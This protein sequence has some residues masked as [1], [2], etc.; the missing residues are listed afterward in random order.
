[1]RYDLYYLKNNNMNKLKDELNK[2]V[3]NDIKLVIKELVAKFN[4]AVVTAPTPTPQPVQAAEMPMV[5]VKTKDGVI[6]QTESL[7]VGKPV[8]QVTPD[9]IVDVADGDYELET[10]EIVTVVGG[11]ISDIK[12]V[13]VESVTEEAPM[14]NAEMESLKATVAQLSEMVAKLS[15]QVNEQHSTIGVTLSAINSI[16]EQPAA[17]PI[18]KPNTI[19]K[20]NKQFAALESIANFKKQK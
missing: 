16:I 7:E 12:K 4:E 11:V 5:E 8:K 9:G 3:P 13:E 20:V 15:S 17:E 2:R 1:M 6:M 18:Q 10:G 14:P 19:T